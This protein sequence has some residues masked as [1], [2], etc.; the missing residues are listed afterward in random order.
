MTK[1]QLVLVDDW[2]L[3]GDGS[4]DMRVIQFD[5]LHKTMDIYEK[6][7]L[8]ASINAEVMQQINHKKWGEQYPDLKQLAKEWDDIII[9]ACQRGHDIQPHTHSQWQGATYENGRW[10][11]PG[12]W[13]IIKGTRESVQSLIH[14]A[15]TYL[16]ELLRPINPN[17]Q[18]VSFRSGAWCI[19]PSDFILSVLVEEG[20]TFDKIGRSHV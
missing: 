6:Y 14:Q 11:L 16:E 7:G 3:R 13:S 5:T 17:Y 15:K 12:N 10:N 4:G 8:K 19:A 1:I 20:F 9:E 2:E 18:C